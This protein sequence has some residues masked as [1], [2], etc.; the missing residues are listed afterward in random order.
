VVHRVDVPYTR[1]KE[2]FYT[3]PLG[4]GVRRWVEGK[5]AGK[6]KG[7]S[8]EKLDFIRESFERRSEAPVEAQKRKKGKT[9]GSGRLER[10]GKG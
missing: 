10:G 9:R 2:N 7:P 1:V 8:S 4:I 5:M 6:L 3:Q